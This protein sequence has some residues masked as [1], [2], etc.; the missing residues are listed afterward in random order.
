MKNTWFLQALLRSIKFE[1]RF[2]WFGSGF[3]ETMAGTVVVV[4]NVLRDLN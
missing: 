4:S 3:W 1:T 2:G